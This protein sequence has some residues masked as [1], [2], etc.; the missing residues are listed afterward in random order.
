MNAIFASGEP[1][2]CPAAEEDCESL[3]RNDVRLTT[4]FKQS[5][6]KSTRPTPV[7]SALTSARSEM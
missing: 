4:K 6:D 5:F 1:V 7:G 2:D 3:K